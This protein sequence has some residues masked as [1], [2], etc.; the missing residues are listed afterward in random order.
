MGSPVPKAFVDLCGKPLFVHAAAP[1]LNRQDCIEAVMAFPAESLD[2]AREEIRNHFP[3]F[4]ISVIAGG[5]TRQESVRLA[6]DSLQSQPDILLIHDAARP[7][8]DDDLI[9]RVL[10]GL[11]REFTG[12][13][14]GLPARNTLKRAAGNPREVRETVSRES[15]YA[16][17]TPQAFYYQEIKKAHRLAHKQGVH[18]TDDAS[19][20]EHFSLGPVR[21]ID[22]DEYNIKITTE[23][24]LALAEYIIERLR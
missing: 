19:L 1:F 13:V 10:T 2:R 12:V 23:R 22:G 21:L 14:P 17:Q 6:I 3:D 7:L 9:E 24:D 11:E 8:V 16:V 5:E 4:Q 20:I 18:G 15:V